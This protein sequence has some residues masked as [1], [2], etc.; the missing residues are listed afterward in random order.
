M[1]DA[2]EWF[3]AYYS[4]VNN[5]QEGLFFVLLYCVVKYTNMF[6]S[7]CKESSCSEF[8][9]PRQRLFFH[10]GINITLQTRRINTR[11]GFFCNIWYHTGWK[12]VCTHCGDWHPCSN[13]LC[14]CMSIVVILT[15]SSQ[16]P[17]CVR[18]GRLVASRLVATASLI[19][20]ERLASWVLW[21]LTMKAL[22]V[23]IM[24]GDG[25]NLVHHDWQCRRRLLFHVATA[26]T[27]DACAAFA[28]TLFTSL[29]N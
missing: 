13:N 25:F 9:N 1:V 29:W 5:L 23:S 28:A 26:T 21:C 19:T 24:I 2:R 3:F 15:T 11:E 22:I 17:Y 7:C 16:H 4:Y 12:L 10:V 18:W 27:S 14:R 8:G 6:Y 20:L